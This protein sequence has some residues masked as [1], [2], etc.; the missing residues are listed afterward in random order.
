[1]PQKPS[2]ETTPTISPDIRDSILAFLDK[3]KMM[4]GYSEQA[5][6]ALENPVFIRARPELEGQV[7]EELFLLPLVHFPEGHMLDLVFLPQES[8]H[9]PHIHDE[10][11][12]FIKIF[13]GTGTASV[14]GVKYS[15]G[16]GSAFLY[17]AG[18]SHGFSTKEGT[19]FI[20][21]QSKPI[22]DQVTGKMDFR[23]PKP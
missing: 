10:S 9:P 19:Y 14:D 15:Y 13:A 20:S 4:V 6:R 7:V 3:Q 11:S 21:L 1:M 22:T 16:E 18:A 2:S 17:P 12:A 23:Y 5:R 8:S